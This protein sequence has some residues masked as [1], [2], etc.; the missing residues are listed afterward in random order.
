MP[1]IHRIRTTI[2]ARNSLLEL[3]AVIA[4]DFLCVVVGSVV[5]HDHFIAGAKRV[6]SAS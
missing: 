6:E 5:H 4:R 3:S 2:H 1:S